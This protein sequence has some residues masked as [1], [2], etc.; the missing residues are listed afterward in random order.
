MTA[1]KIDGTAVASQVYS[2]VADRV[3]IL[4]ATGIRPGLGAIHVG[5]NPASA[6]YLRNKVRACATAGLHSEVHRLPA[7]CSQQAVLETI[8]RLN[9]DPA[10][11]GILVQLPLPAQLD[12]DRI[13]QTIHPD[14]DVD[15]FNWRNLGALLAGRTLFEPCTPRGIVAL[16]DHAGV[17]IEGG[18][19]VIVG[20]SAIV[21]K[22]LALLLLA[23]GATVTA[24]HTKTRNL[25]RY[26]GMADILVAAAG[27]PQLISAP[28]IKPGAAVIDVGINRLDTGKLAGDVDFAGVNEVAGWITPVPGGVGPMTVAMLIDNTLRAAERLAAALTPFSR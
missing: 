6:V 23:R 20:R 26:T 24:C 25:A 13:T 27:R 22:P 2:A 17:P 1:R 10:I 28:M 5:D 16:L 21:G 7:D 12:G 11:H 19:A 18:H 4:A 8:E 3:K 14:K 15:G 9:A